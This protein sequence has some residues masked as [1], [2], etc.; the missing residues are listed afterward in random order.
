MRKTVKFNDNI[1]LAGL[2]ERENN[3]IL[4]I[5]RNIDN[6][7][8]SVA[9]HEFGHLYDYY[10]N[11]SVVESEDTALLWEFKFLRNR[12]EYELINNRTKDILNKLDSLKYKSIKKETKVF[13]L[14]L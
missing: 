4:I 13:Q 10:V 3:I 7:T 1:D 11:G 14:Q 2:Y 12:G 8:I 6:L 9:I 5:P